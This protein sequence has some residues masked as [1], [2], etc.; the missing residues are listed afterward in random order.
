MV[1]H[2]TNYEIEK[3]FQSVYTIFNFR[4]VKDEFKRNVYCDFISAFEGFLGTIYEV[5]KDE[6]YYG[7]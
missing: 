1:L 4:E 6:M 7:Q 5:Y 3:H 2:A